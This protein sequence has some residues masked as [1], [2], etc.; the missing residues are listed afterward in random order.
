MVYPLATSSEK[1]MEHDY[2]IG[3]KEVQRSLWI[4]ISMWKANGERGVERRMGEMGR[5]DI[6]V[7]YENLSKNGFIKETY[8]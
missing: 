7:P 5:E 2:K 6:G 1:L 8:Q 3:D 4:D